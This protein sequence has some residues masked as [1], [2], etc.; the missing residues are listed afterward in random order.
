MRSSNLSLDPQGGAERDPLSL[1]EAGPSGFGDEFSGAEA[2]VRE[3]GGAT[4]R[5]GQ[6]LLFFF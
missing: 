2:G 1:T 6:L 4:G 3:Q 5:G